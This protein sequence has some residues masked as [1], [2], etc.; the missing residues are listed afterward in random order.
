[1]K[2]RRYNI[3][4]TYLCSGTEINN[5][6]FVIIMNTFVYIVS[7]QLYHYHISQSELKF[8]ESL[9]A[10]FAKKCRNFVVMILMYFIL[11]SVN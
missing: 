4:S 1:M 6:S 10:T 8:S 2:K 5:F 9:T 11:C 7:T 3:I